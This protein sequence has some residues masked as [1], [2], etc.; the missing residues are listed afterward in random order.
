MGNEGYRSARDGRP[1]RPLDA[2]AASPLPMLRD[3]DGSVDRLY[4]HVDFRPL[5]YVQVVSRE[6]KREEAVEYR[7][8]RHAVTEETRVIGGD[9]P[10]SPPRAAADYLPGEVELR[11]DWW[12][13]GRA[14]Y[15]SAL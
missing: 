14:A 15:C 2:G 13:V 1:T 6:R 7:L 10:R 3:V 8:I 9:G 11:P 5:E 12:W 4:P